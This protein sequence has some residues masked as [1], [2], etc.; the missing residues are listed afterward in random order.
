MATQGEISIVKGPKTKVWWYNGSL[1]GPTIEAHVGDTLVAHFI[2][3]LPEPSMIH[4]HGIRV[5]ATMDGTKL[6]QKP[7]PPGG[8]FTYRFK[9]QDEGT[10]WYHP[11]MNTAQQVE[12]GLYG[13]IIVK[14]YISD[15]TVGIPPERTYTFILDDIL[16]DSQNHLKPFRP[17]NI[18]ERL[19]QNMN[20]RRGN[21]QLINGK[22]Y[23]VQKVLQRGPLRLKFINAANS[24]YF[25]IHF[26]KHKITQIGGDVGLL[27]KPGGKRDTITIIPGQRKEIIIEPSHEAY[28]EGLE[29]WSV[30]YDQ[31]LHPIPI[32]NGKVDWP[33]IDHMWEMK[34]NQSTMKM[35]HPPIPEDPPKK[36]LTFHFDKGP[37]FPY[38]LPKSFPVAIPLPQAKPGVKR[39][40][41][42]DHGKMKRDGTIDF[43]IN[44]KRFKD[45]T[46]SDAFR[47]KAGNT[48]EWNII[49]LGM[50][51]HPFHI[52]GF[53]FQLL[54]TRFIDDDGMVEEIIIPKVPQIADTINLM[55]A[56]SHGPSKTI[57]KIL[58]DFSP[59]PRAT[60]DILAE[61]GLSAQ[62]RS[63]PSPG[64]W[65]FHCHILEHAAGGMMSYFQV[66]P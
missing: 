22:T 32:K 19:S 7:V 10:Y 12:R 18:K 20:G 51:E 27:S 24:R 48:E 8:K 46:L 65:F 42:F 40:V 23:Q 39:T 54:E 9:L 11:H 5:P 62:K 64:G 1:P 43:Y 29:L 31:G 37:V 36:L 61:G 15:K 53:H 16:L 59:G 45:M 63:L 66:T 47:V 3:K 6:S 13:A 38:N 41:I 4:W 2:N 28:D 26:P 52:H 25:H 50:G 14:N 57:A 17:N 55:G 33:M 34:L 44:G 56:I 58:V 60:K 49:N 35:E 30:H 21:H